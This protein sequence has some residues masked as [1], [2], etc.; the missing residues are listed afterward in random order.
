MLD[1]YIKTKRFTYIYTAVL[2][3]ISAYIMLIGWDDF[4]SLG[5][6][7]V[8][9]QLY[10]GIQILVLITSAMLVLSSRLTDAMLPA[11]MLAVIAT[12]CYNSADKFLTPEFLW[13]AFPVVFSV[14]FHFVKYKG[15][16]KVGRSFWGVCAV[17]LAVTVGGLGS[18]SAADYFSGTS[19]FYVFGLGIGMVIFYLLVK[20][21]IDSDSPENVA[22]VMY[23]TGMLAAFSIYWLYIFQWDLFKSMGRIL[24]P[25]FGNNLSTILMMAI[26]F[27]FYYATKRCVDFVSVIIMY[28]A[29]MLS[30]SRGGIVMGTIEIGILLVLFSI[31][32]Q[33]GIAGI[34][35]RVTYI[36]LILGTTLAIWYFLPE[37]AILGNLVEDPNI[38]RWGVIEM[39]L[40]L[41]SNQNEVRARLIQRMIVDFESNPI[42][43]VGI[44]YT[45]NVDLYNPV[46]GA[47]NWYHMWIPQIVGSL[48]V[49]GIA[50]YGYQ[51]FERVRMTL[52]N[53]SAVLFTFFMSYVGLWLMSQLNPGE[54]CP[55]PYLMLAVTYFAFIEK[56]EDDIPLFKK[57]KKSEKEA[58]AVQE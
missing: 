45:G 19:L 21:Q 17:A 58:A 47:M 18:I 26:P 36:G 10:I 28:G 12:A 43:G 25:Q 54:F 13:V 15:T 31:F 11:M 32:Y 8:N 24:E 53:S 22:R 38:S 2:F 4:D 40:T 39:L 46:K 5:H 52:K 30:G 33:K 20:S 6:V 1:K 51:L 49:V 56:K 50:A 42:F 44:G 27:A 37:I 41:T 55:A 14:I 48:G 23:M 16:F 35:N 34:V 7:I 3:L 57:K 9:Q 29:M